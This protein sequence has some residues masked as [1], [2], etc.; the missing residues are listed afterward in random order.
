MA[1]LPHDRFLAA[2]SGANWTVVTSA[3]LGTGPNP[4]RAEIRRGRLHRRLL[5]YAWRITPEGKGRTKAGR[6]DQDYRIQTTRSHQGPLLNLPG[7]LGCG[8]GWDDERDVFA[9]F[10]PWVKRNTGSSSSVHIPR[11]LLDGAAK[12]AW[13]ELERP[14]HGP[15]AGFQPSEVNHFLSWATELGIRRLV[16]LDPTK[17]ERDDE[18]ATVV[19]DP[20]AQHLAGWLRPGDRIVLVRSSKLVDDSVWTIDQIGAEARGTASG[21]YHRMLLRFRCVRYGVIRDTAWLGTVKA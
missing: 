13:S 5:V 15:E 18:L 4:T 11:A 8:I 1:L 20:W 14:E 7:Y 3:R 16:Q 12:S 19:V 6:Q 17:F 21:N 2:L 10:D 9:A